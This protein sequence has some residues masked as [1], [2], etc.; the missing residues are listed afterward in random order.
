MYNYGYISNKRL[1]YPFQLFLLFI[2]NVQCIIITD[3]YERRNK[4]D[5]IVRFQPSTDGYVA[6]ILTRL[7][8]HENEMSKLLTQEQYQDVVDQREIKHSDDTTS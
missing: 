7:Q 1:T 5:C 2:L 3:M 4:F 6:I 8:S